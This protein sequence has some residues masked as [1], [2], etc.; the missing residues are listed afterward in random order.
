MFRSPRRTFI[1]ALAAA[2]VTVWNSPTV[3]AGDADRIVVRDAHLLISRPNAP[4][5]AAFM[6]LSNEG[7]TPDRL[8]EVSSDLA[9]RIELH[10]HIASDDGVMRMREVEDGFSV[11][12]GG[13]HRLE[14]GSDHVMMMGLTRALSSGDEVEM[15]LVFETAGEIT[16]TFLVGLAGKAGDGSDSG[17]NDNSN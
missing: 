12:A 6:V 17:Q 9:K 1:V 5:A 3:A 8:I 16:V 14:R 7:E 11:P 10:T 4:S 2:L 13:T 15:T